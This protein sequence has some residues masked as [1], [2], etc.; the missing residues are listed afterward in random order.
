MFKLKEI[1]VDYM[2]EPITISGK[3]TFCW[4]YEDGSDEEQVSYQIICTSEDGETLYDSGVIRSSEMTDISYEGKPLPSRSFINVEVKTFSNKGTSSEM[5]THFE[6]TLKDSEWHG[7]WTSIP[8]NFNGGTLYFRKQFQLKEKEIKRARCYICGIGY[9]EFYLNGEKVGDVVLNPGVTNYDKTL[10]FDTY[11][12]E[13]YLR[14]KDNVMGVEV[15]YGWFG[16]RKLFL[17]L[18]IEYTDGEIYEDY[19]DCNHGWWVS[20]TPVIDN[21]I[22]GGETYDARIERLTSPHWC[23]LEFQ[24]TW[25]NGWM[26]TIL[27]QIPQGKLTPQQV[28]PIRVLNE[29]KVKSVKKLDETHFVYDLGQN[30]AGWVQIKV[31]GEEG[32][33]IT[34]IY[35]EGVKEDGHANQLN[36]RSAKCRDTYILKGE[37]EETYAPRFTYHGFQYVEAVIEGKAEILE[38]VGKHVHSDIEVVGK[39]VCDDEKLNRLHRMAVITEQNNQYS[40]LTD[41]PQRDE[42]FGWL[43]DVS[44]RVFQSNY[45]FDMDRMYNKVVHDIF[46]TQ[47]EQGCIADTAPYYTGGQPADTTTVSYLLLA[48]SAYKYYG[49]K[50]LIQKEYEGHKKWVDYL[51]TRQKD[52]IMDYYYYADWVSPQSLKNP[53][54]D[55]IFVS[56][57]FL[58]WH[59]LTL[60]KLAQIIGKAEDEKK[61]ADLATLSKKSLNEHYYK[62][63]GYYCNNTQCENAMPVW[64]GICEEKNKK[65]V[66]EHIVKDIID[67]NY[68]LT[69][70]N[71][72]YRHVFYLLCEYGYSD[73][74][75]KVLENSEY[76][77]WGYMLEK[78]ATTVWERWEAEMQNEMHSFDHPM[79]G[80]YDAIFYRYILGI[81]VGGNGADDIRIEP[82]IP[83]SLTYAKGEFKSI[84]GT[85][86]S[87]WVKEKDKIRYSF[88]I[89][90]NTSAKIKLMNEA[91]TINGKEISGKEFTLQG[92]R[93]EITTRLQEEKL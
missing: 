36:L 49:D 83:N 5:K 55:G 27:T 52:F 4:N 67:N 88:L 69:C 70:G 37:G 82:I 42:R 24:P 79:F 16:S 7:K 85:I 23:S 2:I 25:A 84:K 93:Y 62:A 89:P 33:K 39:F 47:N 22:Y 32:S 40:I 15:G 20:G 86:A 26:Y 43:N 56:S 73:L 12:I 60:S 77:G 90:G 54:S 81:Q 92:G 13:K 71:Q 76:P 14:K 68:H 6:T 38:M 29:Y 8:D 66:V 1:K 57:M 63:E 19:S 50:K 35:A 80:S 65:K 91:L 28:A 21:S 48:L 31:K 18:Y 74:A 59:L 46:E 3:P 51:L 75:I 44:S 30:M 45:N 61:Y 72:G 58:Y 9:H 10:L 34:L 64:L 41:C 78:G 53:N 11:K 17:Q 87:S